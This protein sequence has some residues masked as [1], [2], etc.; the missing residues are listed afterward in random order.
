[1]CVVS[2]DVPMSPEPHVTRHRTGHI[3]GLISTERTHT[4]ENPLHTFCVLTRLTYTVQRLGLE[5]YNLCCIDF[6]LKKFSLLLS[7]YCAKISPSGKQLSV[8]DTHLANPIQS[9][10]R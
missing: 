3:R 7:K 10:L 5:F 2:L 4:Y 6:I 9:T 1:V 8:L